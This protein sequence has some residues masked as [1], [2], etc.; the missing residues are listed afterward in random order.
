MRSRL[1]L[2]RRHALS[3]DQIGCAPGSTQYRYSELCDDEIEEVFSDEEEG[4][5]YNHGDDDDPYIH[6]A[7]RGATTRLSTSTSRS[8]SQSKT[9]IGSDSTTTIARDHN[10]HELLVSSQQSSPQHDDHQDPTQPLLMADD[11]NKLPQ[12]RRQDDG[13]YHVSC[14]PMM[15]PP[16]QEDDV[17]STAFLVQPP[18]GKAI[19][20]SALSDEA[21]ETETSIFGIIAEQIRRDKEQI[22]QQILQPVQHEDVRLDRIIDL[23]CENETNKPITSHSY[24]IKQLQ[25]T[26]DKRLR[27]HDRLFFEL[28][29]KQE[30]YQQ[31]RVD[32]QRL[33]M[34][35]QR[36]LSRINRIRIGIAKLDS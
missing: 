7:A 6:T 31:V 21:D 15:E 20:I 2:V 28:V 16:E 22:H 12:Q 26:L 11:E 4:H 23:G 10:Y 14:T 9:S 33:T 3:C 36:S 34:K 19:S 5:E 27:K 18:N 13:V 24:A 30:Q 29:Q 25:K 8:A 32:I 17:P 1:A 35:R